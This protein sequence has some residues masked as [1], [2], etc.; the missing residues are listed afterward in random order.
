VMGIEPWI[1][2]TA[3]PGETIHWKYNYLYYTLP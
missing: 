1:H 2:L 3:A